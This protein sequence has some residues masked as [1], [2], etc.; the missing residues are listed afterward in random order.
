[1]LKLNIFTYRSFN[2]IK[3]PM[4]SGM[5]P[6]KLL[7]ERTLFNLNYLLQNNIII[8]ITNIYTKLY[9]KNLFII[10][11]KYFYLQWS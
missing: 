6:L 10:I 11:I 4:D 3:F 9:Y 7:P 1:M 5:V 8:N 2:P